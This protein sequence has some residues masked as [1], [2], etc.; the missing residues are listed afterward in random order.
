[1][2]RGTKIVQL[3]MPRAAGLSPHSYRMPWGSQEI[4]ATHRI[5]VPGANDEEVTVLSLQHGE[6]NAGVPDLLHRPVLLCYF[7]SVLTWFDWLT[8]GRGTSLV[9]G[10]DRERKPLVEVTQELP[11]DWPAHHADEAY[12]SWRREHPEL[13]DAAWLEYLRARIAEG[14]ISCKYSNC[15]EPLVPGTLVCAAH[16]NSL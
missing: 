8:P 14:R 12:H 10:F 2:T 16:Q 4:T 13:P 5:L 7:N 15:E 3:E 1:M 6:C 11:I 9:I